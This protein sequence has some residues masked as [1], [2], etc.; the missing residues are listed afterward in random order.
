MRLHTRTWGGSAADAVV[1]VHGLNQHGGIF[2]PLARQLVQGG[3]YVVSVDLRGHG[4]SGKE[5]PWDIDTHV[6]D[7]V[8]TIDALGIERAALVAHSFGA[9]LIATLANRAPERVSRLALLD[10]GLYVPPDRALHRA[11][12]DRLDWSFATVAGA[13]NALLASDTIVA[14]PE[15]VVAAYVEDDVERGADGRFRFSF[16]PSAVVVAWSEMARPAPPIAELPTLMVAAMVPLQ[17]GRD[18]IRRYREA[19]G[20]LLKVA[21][22]PNGHNVLWESPV[23]TT[24]AVEAFLTAGVPAS[25]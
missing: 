1:C 20:S 4:Q 24:A 22:V 21:T 18:Q 23:E 10:A 11:E 5:P 8:E 12:L 17:D 2:E 6:A 15:E 16:C 14:A 25:P 19:L 7:L 9:R 13:T 3:R